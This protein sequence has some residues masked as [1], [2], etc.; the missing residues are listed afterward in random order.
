MASTH[1]YAATTQGWHCINLRNGNVLCSGLTSRIVSSVAM[2]HMQA[3]STQ[4]SEGLVLAA[5]PELAEVHQMM[6][7]WDGNTAQVGPLGGLS[8]WIHTT[9]TTCLH[10]KW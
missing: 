9:L 1:L 7:W 6:S 3:S 10:P 2:A 8:T 5:C 4:P